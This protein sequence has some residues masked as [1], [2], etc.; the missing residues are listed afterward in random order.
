MTFECTRWI[1]FRKND[2]TVRFLNVQKRLCRKSDILTK[3]IFVLI[4]ELA[5]SMREVNS[6]FFG[7][8]FCKIFGEPMNAMS[9]DVGRAINQNR[10]GL[11]P[12]SSLFQI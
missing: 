3:K 12:K 5:L 7:R 8:P 9:A 1:T 6:L 10:S 2:Q 4:Y 11:S